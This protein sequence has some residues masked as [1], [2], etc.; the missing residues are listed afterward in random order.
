MYSR[1]DEWVSVD[2][3]VA[4]I[5]VTDY[6]QDQLSDVVYVEITRAVGDTADRNQPVASIESVK[7]ASDVSAP[8]SGKVVAVN[9]ALSKTPEIINKDPYGEG[10]IL[11]VEIADPSQIKTLLSPEDYQKYCEE[12][13]S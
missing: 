13:S 10:W 8:V 3:N 4:T 6:A 2:G 5:G 12:R 9:E 7:A 1:S 11:K